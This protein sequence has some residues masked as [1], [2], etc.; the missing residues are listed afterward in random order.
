M[1]NKFCLSPVAQSITLFLGGSLLLSD[2]AV[3]NHCLASS[4]NGVCGL[5]EFQMTSPLTPVPMAWYFTQ[6]TQDA[7]IGPAAKAQNIY[8]ASGTASRTANDVQR[9]LVSGAQLDGYYINASK[10]G[11]AVITLAD[12]ASVDWLEAGGANASTHTTILIDDSTLNGAN[13]AVDYEGKGFSSKNY[14]RGFAIYVDIQDKGDQQ[15]TVAHNSQVSGHIVTGGAGTHNVGI[16]DSHMNKGG[17][18][19]YGGAGD[20]TVTVDN[21][22]IDSRNS[23]ISTDAAI[24]IAGANNHNSALLTNSSLT[25]SVKMDGAGS[26]NRLTLAESTVAAT[27]NDKQNAVSLVNGDEAWLTATQSVLEGNVELTAAN[28]IVSDI[29]GGHITGGIG[30][31]QAQDIDVT[32]AGATL[33]GNLDASAGVGAFTL[34]LTDNAV[35]KGDVLLDG[36]LQHSAVLID[37]A[38][39]NGHLYG[40]ADSALTLGASIREF[41]G[42]AFSGF[43]ALNLSGSLMLANGFSDSNVGQALRV[44][45]GAVSAPVNLSQGR[46]TFNASRLM[47]DTLAL[48]DSAALA[49]THNSVLET[50]SSQLFNQAASAQAT[51]A[52]GFTSSGAHIQLNDSTLA[53]TDDEYTLEYVKSVHGLLAGQPSAA[54]VMMGQLVNG[55]SAAGTATVQ[56]AAVTGAVLANV[57]VTSDKN[58][59][60]IGAQ[61]TDPE[62]AAVANGFGAAQLQFTGASAPA[63]TIEGNQTLTLTGARGGPLM[64][65]AGEAAQNAVINVNNGT[66]N[67]GTAATGNTASVLDGVINVASQGVMNVAGGQHAITHQGVISRGV[68]NIDKEAG[69]KANIQ[70]EDQAQLSVAGRLDADLLT[71]SREASIIVGDDNS[72]GVLTA[73]QVDLNG[74]MLFIDPLWQAGQS[75]MNASRVV[76]GGN[77]INGRLTAGQNSL[78]MLGDADINEINNAIAVSGLKWGDDITA[79]LAINAPQRLDGAQGGLRVDG[80]LTLSND[81]ALRSAGVNRAD[82]GEHSLLMVNGAA[83]AEGSAALVASAGA[84]S[85]AGS[86]MLYLPDA[87]ANKNYV[88]AEGFSSVDIQG[89][90]WRNDNLLT[91]R[92]LDATLNQSDSGVSVATTAKRASDVLPGVVMTHALDKMMNTNANALNSPYGGIRF[93]STAVETPTVENAAIVQTINSAAQLAIAGGVQ[94]SALAASDAATNAIR[95]RNTQSAFEQNEEEASVWVNGLYGGLSSD[96]LAAAGGRYGYESDFYGVIVGADKN[97]RVGSGTARSGIAFNTGKGQATSRGDFND[98]RNDFTFSGVSLYQGWRQGAFNVAADAGYS[99][100]NHTPEQ[101]LPGWMGIGDKLK[102][103]IDA[104]VLTVGL[105]G[106][107]RV[108]ASLLAITP[109]AGVRYNQIVTNAFTTKTRGGEAVFKTEKERQSVWQFPVGVRA[110]KTYSLDSGWKLHAGADMS[111]VF[112]TGDTRSTSKV[113]ATGIRASD[114]L[115]AEVTDT[116]AFQGAVGLALQKGNVNVGIGYNMNASSHNTGQNV[117]ITYRLAF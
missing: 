27:T 5:T 72:A 109:H 10:N 42:Q 39:V 102:A 2:N 19:I 7:V 21:S 80:S 24:Q 16:S 37:N 56:D 64:T 71:A 13:G 62:I 77:E 81:A 88:I 23:V 94:A 33:D 34:R 110:D 86:A 40:G 103:D 69:L 107:Y 116:T 79:G 93:L 83:T 51:T 47:A 63:V 55:D 85:V 113:R 35:I 20:N 66:F 53:L 111:M 58:N 114:T 15:V 61:T 96:D 22:V 112:A 4:T 65:T 106:E 60:L 9:L 59:L 70:L 57:A 104:S 89:N 11:S 44:T 101:R 117:S 48:S 30:L 45:G 17:V 82:F 43:N 97:Y 14:A 26:V 74:A 54:L 18:L 76:L 38:Q 75:L 6:K 92:L 1:E 108:D 28:R 98:T 31:G 91:N 3:A 115:S 84:L 95:D 41:N 46:L 8:F 100:S 67:L 36:A 12:N 90:G 52:D 32:L 105:N 87:Q 29:T 78:L 99:E 25:G 49:F 73:G 68:I 50:R